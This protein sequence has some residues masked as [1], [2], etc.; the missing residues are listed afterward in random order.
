MKKIIMILLLLSLLSLLSIPSMSIAQQGKQP[1]QCPGVAIKIV[2]LLMVRPPCI[3]ISAASTGICA[4]LSPLTYFMGIGEASTRVLIEAPWRFT[5]YRYL[6]EFN[7][8]K[9]DKP[10]TC[11]PDN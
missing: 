8:Y 9:D 6:G 4:A 2:D 5:A 11:V 1:D 3:G 10:I 7:H